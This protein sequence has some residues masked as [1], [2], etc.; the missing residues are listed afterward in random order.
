MIKKRA[1]IGKNY[2]L[3]RFSTRFLFDVVFFQKKRFQLLF[4]FKNYFYF[5]KL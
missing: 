5:C 4:I 2:H 3:H 1:N